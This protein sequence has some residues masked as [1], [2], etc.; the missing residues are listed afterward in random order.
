MEKL[1]LVRRTELL[2]NIYKELCGD[3][4]IKL[5]CYAFDFNLD[6]KI[7]EV[8]ASYVDHHNCRV[9]GRKLIDMEDVYMLV[10]NDISREFSFVNYYYPLQKYFPKISEAESLFCSDKCLKIFN[11]RR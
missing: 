1:T 7:S 9:C 10:E 8:L 3:Y 6:L 4:F 5:D 2:E 11:L